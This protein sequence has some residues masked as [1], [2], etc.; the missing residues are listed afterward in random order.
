M[1][2]QLKVHSSA[3]QRAEVMLEF[4]NELLFFVL[5]KLLMY[6]SQTLKQHNCYLLFL[7]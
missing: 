3:L 2:N 1:Y 6:R 4:D 5:V 7:F